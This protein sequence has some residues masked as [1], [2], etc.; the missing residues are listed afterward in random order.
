[1]TT[2]AFARA[3]RYVRGVPFSVIRDVSR[4]LEPQ[5]ACGTFAWS[6]LN[7]ETGGK[8]WKALLTGRAMIWRCWSDK[9]R[10]IP[11]HAV[12]WL[13]GKGWIDSTDRFWRD[14]PKP[15]RRAWPMGAP[16]LAGLALLYF[17]S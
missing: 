12:L 4:D 2:G 16:V 5:G 8:P 15:N 14:S 13:R 1:M 6:V 10:T 17:G 11:R 7:I 3:Y 9:N